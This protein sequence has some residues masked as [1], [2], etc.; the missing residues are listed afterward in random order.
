MITSKD[1]I[2]EHDGIVKD[3]LRIVF[4][5]EQGPLIAGSI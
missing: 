5:E 3:K 4:K 2:K 1:C